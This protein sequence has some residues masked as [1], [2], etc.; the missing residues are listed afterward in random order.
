MPAAH[1]DWDLPAVPRGGDDDP[2]RA[3]RR[4]LADRGG[5]REQVLQA[6]AEWV[7]EK[8]LPETSDG[9][10]VKFAHSCDYD[11]ER[12]KKCVK[13]FYSTRAQAADLF[14][15]WDTDLPNIR[16]I[17]D[18]I[19]IAIMPRKTPDNYRVVVNSL[20][21]P[22]TDAYVF[23]DVC[24]V[25]LM[26]MES[27]FLSEPTV[28]GLVVVHDMG[29]ASFAH[30]MKFG[31]AVPKKL[32][33]YTQEALPLKQQTMHLVN[34]SGFIDKGLRLMSHIGRKED[35][36]RLSVHRGDDHTEL[37]RRVPPDCLPS[38]LGG[39]LPPLA[40]LHDMTVR[41]LAAFKDVF[42]RLLP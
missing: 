39:T 25:L 13:S 40:E 9:A 23:V 11:L 14:S 31:W 34:C 33:A 17:L 20:H 8:K 5:P 16:S 32:T 18:V 22:E 26:V 1:E 35:W 10:L 3:A 37:H 7:R 42:H 30:F 2:G 4:V 28:D 36:E 38:D 27:V 15:G 29:K 41:R 24:R 12:S 21:T 6:L 19:I